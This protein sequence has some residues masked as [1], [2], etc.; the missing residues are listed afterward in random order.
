MIYRKN[1]LPVSIERA[2]RIVEAAVTALDGFYDQEE[3]NRMWKQAHEQSTAGYCAR[4]IIEDNADGFTMRHKGE[5]LSY[6][7]LP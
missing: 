7:Q 4:D 2:K 1:G 3:T 5:E 6:D